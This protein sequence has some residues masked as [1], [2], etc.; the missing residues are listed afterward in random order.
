MTSWEEFGPIIRPEDGGEWERGG[1]YK[2]WIMQMDGRFWLFYNAKTTET[3]SWHEQTGAATS[4]DLM[5]WQRVADV[6]LLP[7]GD[8][9]DAD[10][11][12]ASD[13]CVLFDADAERWV[14]F[15]FGLQ[16]G[17]HARELYATST[18]LLHWTK[19]GVLIDIGEEGDI[20]EVHAH[21]PAVFGR[22]RKLEHYYCAVARRAVPLTIGGT[23][24][25]E[26]RGITKAVE[27]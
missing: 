1:L 13:P 3:P 7:H 26:L 22:D 14:M 2:A 9:G 12:F 21:K 15:Y 25:P 4:D 17:G 24:Q 10:E 20:D 8:S 27:S 18:D 5:T 6:P 16:T 19:G 23:A 11:W